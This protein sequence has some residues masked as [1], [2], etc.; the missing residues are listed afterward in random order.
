MGP[1]R[2]S[3]AEVGMLMLLETATGPLWIWIWLNEAPS[4]KALEGGSL[5]VGTLLIHGFIKWR[6][7][8]VNALD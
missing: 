1:M 3:A 8:R 4:K 5:V 2:I 7:T 6:S